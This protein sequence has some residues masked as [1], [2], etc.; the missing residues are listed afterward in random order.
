M[1]VLDA[2]QPY[3]RDPNDAEKQHD[4]YRFFSYQISESELVVHDLVHDTK[5]FILTDAIEDYNF[6]NWLVVC[7]SVQRAIRCPYW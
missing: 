2:C 5:D 1:I 7:L 3:P 4:S 6:L